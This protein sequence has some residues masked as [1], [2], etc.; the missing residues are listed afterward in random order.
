MAISHVNTQTSTTANGTSATAT[1][2]TGTASGDLLVGVFTSNSQ[3]CTPPAGWTEILDSVI[4]V[5]R[6]QVFYKVAGGSEPAN[7]AFSVPAAAPLILT[8]SAFRG[9]DTTTPIDISPV[10]EAVLDHAEAYTTPSVSGGTVGRLLFLRAVRESGS[11]PATFTAGATELADVGVYSGGS[12]CY[13]AGLYMAGSDYVTSGSQSG[14][15]ITCSL[16]EEHNIVATL[17]IRSSSI[18]GTMALNLPIPSMSA[19]GSW[20]IPAA[21][22]ADLPQLDMDAGAFVGQ[23]EGTLNVQVPIVASVTGTVQPRGSMDVSILP[24]IDVKA[25]TRRFSDDIMI[26][27]R[28]ERWLIMTQDG[29]RLGVRATTDLPLRIDLP[30][31]LVSLL[32]SGLPQPDTVSVQSEAFAPTV[33]SVILAP[34]GTASASVTAG[35]AA[36]SKLT[37]VG[38]SAT[39]NG[40][41]VRVAPAVDTVV[42]SVLVSDTVIPISAVAIASV[43]VYDATVTSTAA[44]SAGTVSTSAVAND[45]V[46]SRISPALVVATA[47]DATVTGV[48]A[49]SAGLASAS[50]ATNNA[51]GTYVIAENASL[52]ATA[53]APT[54]TSVS[55]VAAYADEPVS[56]SITANNAGAL[57][58]ATSG[59]TSVSMTANDAAGTYVDPE[60][61]TVGAVANQPTVSILDMIKA[62]SGAVS[63][64]ASSNSPTASPAATPAPVSVPVAAPAAGTQID[65][66]TVPVVVESPIVSTVNSIHA[67]AGHVTVA[68]D[69][70]GAPAEGETVNVTGAVGQPSVLNEALADHVSVTC[71][72]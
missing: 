56:A 65:S 35:D 14:L 30:L 68:F 46:V 12:V 33:V 11:T 41:T 4:D 10:S 55:M 72:N 48:V 34:A 19:A 53:N 1:K 15:A 43:A 17:G 69:S 23:Y 49:A 66:V 51:A 2:P 71:H 47:N 42:V 36:I 37:S 38:V 9:I 60:S 62:P 18:P 31:I 52:T 44:P 40:A 64:S 50:I 3:D 29:Y 61:A 20:A 8:V 7:Y 13:S 45:A 16:T 67:N 70:G 24:M 21:L 57:V 28:E 59:L 32:G 25:E 54:V 5:F 63:V 39:A 58:S 26:I 6:C 22:D 27:E